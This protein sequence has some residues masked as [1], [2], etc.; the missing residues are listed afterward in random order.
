MDPLAP[1]PLMTLLRHDFNEWINRWRWVPEAIY[2]G[3]D[4]YA[5]F[6]LEYDRYFESLPPHVRFVHADGI[7]RFKGGRVWR[8]QSPGI[9]WMLERRDDEYTM[10]LY[11]VAE[12]KLE[13]VLFSPPMVWGVVEG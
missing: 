5:Q 3:P 4:E 13:P 2:L 8:Q 7:P 10:R 11:Q 12:Q 6:I 1:Y 9:G